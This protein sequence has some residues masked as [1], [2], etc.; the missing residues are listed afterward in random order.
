MK[1][2]MLLFT[3]FAILLSDISV[4][5]QPLVTDFQVNDNTTETLQSNDA[6]ASLNDLIPNCVLFTL[7]SY[8]T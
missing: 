6:I 1:T 7:P 8:P 5:A 2:L 3:L 4:N